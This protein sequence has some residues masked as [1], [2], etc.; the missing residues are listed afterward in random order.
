LI[1]QKKNREINNPLL[2]QKKQLNQKKED[3]LM[4]KKLNQLL[5]KN[6]KDHLKKQKL[7]RELMLQL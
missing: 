5:Q 6:K 4:L 1:L 7:K 3:L 2:V